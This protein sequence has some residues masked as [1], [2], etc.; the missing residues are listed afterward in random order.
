MNSESADENNEETVNMEVGGSP[1]AAEVKLEDTATSKPSESA[2]DTVDFNG[3][4]DS[5]A[6]LKRPHDCEDAGSPPSKISKE[7]DVASEVVFDEKEDPF[8]AE[9][10]D[11]PVS[12]DVQAGIDDANTPDLTCSEQLSTNCVSPD[13]YTNEYLGN[14][15]F[16]ANGFDGVV[17]DAESKEKDSSSS[18]DE[19]KSDEAKSEK[20][21]N[22]KAPKGRRER[23]TRASSSQSSFEGS[24][25]QNGSSRETSLTHI[26]SPTRPPKYNFT[27]D[28]GK[29]KIHS[30]DGV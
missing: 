13:P 2:N 20:L 7:D 1:S 12:P 16:F 3:K 6:T 28:L 21:T 14:D 9:E 24:E 23:K 4:I 29:L 26:S 15:V 5:K 17:N 30:E 27:D 25:C 8:P 19:A 10:P 11:D 18:V 22:R